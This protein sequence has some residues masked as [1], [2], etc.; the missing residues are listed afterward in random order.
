M[1]WHIPWHQTAEAWYRGID[2]LN[3]AK[4][5]GAK[6]KDK[7][8][9][10]SDSGQLYLQVSTTGGKH[11]RMN[12]TYGRNS[13]GK[14][15]QKTLAFG[16][17]PAVT[18]LDARRQRDEAK[19]LLRDGK[20]PAVE[21]RVASRTR[22]AANQNTFEV[23][24]G[25]WFEL[26]SGWSIEKLDAY[27]DARGG[28]WSH[29]TAAHW[30]T[31]EA[32][33]SDVHSADVL[34]SLERDIFPHIGDLPITT[35]KAPKL[36][37]VLQKVEKRGAIETAHRLRQR[38]SAVFVYG[39]GAGLCEADP[40][41]SLGATLKDVPKSKKQPSIIDGIRD[42]DAR[43]AA[44][45]KMMK[46][47][48]AERCRATTK[49]ALRFHLLTAV[50]PNELYG[51]RW[52]EMTDLD[53]DEPTWTIPALRMKGDKDRKAEEQGEH[54]VPLSRQAVDVLQAVR[55]LTGRLPLIFPGERH[56]HKEMSD[57]TLRALLIRAGYYQ[58]HVPHGF[59]AAF[60]TIMNERAD[61]EWRETGH[62]GA[63]P[64]RAIIDLM[65]AHVPGNKV[66]S[67]YNRAAYL[68]RRRELA[69]EY[70]DIVL[71]GFC[72]AADH[73]GGPIRY[74]ATGPGRAKVDA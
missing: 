73:L 51:A 70:A 38:C 22:E 12:Y 4:I 3:D 56:V 8:Y 69:Q 33:W 67:A 10:L 9:R 64:D 49:L 17:Y 29:R 74:A 60:S 48:E 65:L 72:P 26:N 23:V 7:P 28:K 53:G 58:R 20:D 59:R 68:P 45:R 43:I 21:K 44:V 31:S 19:A 42:Q 55:K 47:C 16:S 5:K 6:G 66:E 24:A 30:R 35:I 36:L 50:R 52:E 27:R 57:N 25:R 46:D 54:V 13:A 63:S 14:P 11:W 32:P 37:E 34:T 39:I 41:A 18:L 15:A 62:Q 40:A 1:P 61:R 71:E 2:V